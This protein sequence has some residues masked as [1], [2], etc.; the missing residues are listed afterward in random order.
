[1]TW[2]LDPSHT[3]VGF[4]AKHLGLTT[5]HGS[6]ADVSADIE[7]DDEA[8]PTT[9]KGR[10]VVKTAS[11]TTGHEQ[12]DGHL[13]SPD[14]FDTEQYPEITF[15]ATSVS[16]KGGDEY[17]VVGNLTVKDITKEISLHYEHGGVVTDPYGNVKVGGSLTATVN[18]MDWG[19]KWNVPLGGGGLLVGEKVKIEVEGQLAKVK[20]EAAAS[21]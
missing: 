8:N 19:L 2:T 7:L 4:S 6:F 14:F 20:E 18:R 12:R 9:A 3:V 15:E 21:A 10:V 11:L 13:R 5:V 17:D 1:M 16:H